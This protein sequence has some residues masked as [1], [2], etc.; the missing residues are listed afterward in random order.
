MSPII[1]QDPKGPCVTPEAEHVRANK[2]GHCNLQCLHK[3]Q[4]MPPLTSI[5]S[6]K[7]D[8]E[9]ECVRPV[10]VEAVIEETR[11]LREPTRRAIADAAQINAKLA[12][13][14]ADG[15]QLGTK[16]EVFRAQFG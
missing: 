7:T 3:P 9:V 8:S 11:D 16:G 4:R 13:M 14:V 2:P 1:S 6:D 15:V 5:A 12:Q 10:W